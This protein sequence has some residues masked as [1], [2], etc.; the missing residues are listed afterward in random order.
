MCLNRRIIEGED[1]T[2]KRITRKTSQEAAKALAAEAGAG[3]NPAPAAEAAE[4]RP[5]V[6][7]IHE[8]LSAGAPEEIGHVPRGWGPQFPIAQLAHVVEG[9]RPDRI[10]KLDQGSAMEHF[11]YLLLLP[12]R[13]E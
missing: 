1:S 11:R 10:E 9:V 13:R 6:A 7:S 2:F 8:M 4:T 12:G 3:P 5:R